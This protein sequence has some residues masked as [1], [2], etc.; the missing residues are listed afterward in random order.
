MIVVD[1]NNNEVAENPTTNLGDFLEDYR[2]ETK[3]YG[4]LT[5]NN[6]NLGIQSPWH[7]DNG[8]RRVPVRYRQRHRR[9]DDR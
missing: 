1:R 7:F 9:I 4:D 5:A 6:R 8:T 2:F 3:T